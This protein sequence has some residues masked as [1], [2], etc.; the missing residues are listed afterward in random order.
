MNE[1]TYK[2]SLKKICEGILFGIEIETCYHNVNKSSNQKPKTENDKY[3][4]SLI[5]N[6]K[7]LFDCFSKKSNTYKNPMINWIYCH[8]HSKDCEEYK[9]WV[10]TSDPTVFCKN[11]NLAD[12][13]YSIQK[14]QISTDIPEI[15][16]YPVEIVSPILNMSTTETEAGEGFLVISLIY[17]GWLIDNNLVYTI[18][19]TQGLHI[20]LSHTSINMVDY[21]QKFIKILYIIEPILLNMIPEDRRDMIDD[22]K[23]LRYKPF[24]KLDLQS[25]SEKNPIVKIHTNRIELRL[26]DGTMIYDEIY[27]TTMLSILLLGASIVISHDYLNTLLNITDINKLFEV[28]KTLIVDTNTINFAINKYNKNKLENSPHLN[29]TDTQQTIFPKFKFNEKYNTFLQ[30]ALNTHC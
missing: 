6:K 11:S 23:K 29:N 24:D 16:F 8:P 5:D 26:F 9:K 10:V 1:N 3:K 27:Y 12:E 19:N 7:Y 21:S 22:Y 17:F 25:L 2:T 20:N 4:Q 30:P 13:T 18:N 14:Q 28:L 15:E